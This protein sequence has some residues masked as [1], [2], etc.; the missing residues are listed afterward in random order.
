[1]HTGTKSGTAK[2]AVCTGRR[3]ENDGIY[4]LIVGLFGAFT[5]D[6]C[7]H[8]AAVSPPVLSH[9]RAVRTMLAVRR[10]AR[11]RIDLQIKTQEA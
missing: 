4:L 11:M 5:I 6:R 1:M 9:G 7:R 10:C 2:I 3:R 8:A